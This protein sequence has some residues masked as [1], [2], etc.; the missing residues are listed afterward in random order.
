[1]STIQLSPKESVTVSAKHG[2]VELHMIQGFLALSTR[3][4]PQHA[5]QLAQ[6]LNA[7]ADQLLHPAVPLEG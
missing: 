3:I 2:Q 7:A 5:R 1:M 6:A 4:T